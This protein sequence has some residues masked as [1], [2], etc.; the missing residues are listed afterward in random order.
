MLEQPWPLYEN[1]IYKCKSNSFMEWA[2]QKWTNIPGNSGGHMLL[3]Y[4]FRFP[5]IP[6][7]PTF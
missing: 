2:L 5:S 6:H 3:K 1:C 7:E 4:A